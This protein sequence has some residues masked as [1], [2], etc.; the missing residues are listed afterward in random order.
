MKSRIRE[1]GNCIVRFEG[2]GEREFGVVW[3]EME[4]WRAVLSC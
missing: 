4:R 3:G 1:E 2:I